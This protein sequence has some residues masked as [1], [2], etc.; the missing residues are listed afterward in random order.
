[1]G[2]LA[3]QDSLERFGLHAEAPVARR[4]FRRGQHVVQRRQPVRRSSGRQALKD[5]GVPWASPVAQGYPGEDVL[6][7][8]YVPND[9]T[10]DVLETEDEKR[11]SSEGRWP[12][13][14]YYGQPTDFMH[15]NDLDLSYYS[16]RDGYEGSLYDTLPSSYGAFLDEFDE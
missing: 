3:G 9:D 1:M 6:G 14:K 2:M 5:W 13:V 4:S 15:N 7:G 12:Y 8:P 11:L 16:Y 10:E